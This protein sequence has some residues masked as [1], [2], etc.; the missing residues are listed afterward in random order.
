MHLIHQAK[1]TKNWWEDAVI[2]QIYPKSF[3]SSD[4]KIGDL[5]G[6]TSHLTHLAKLGVDALWISPFYTSPQKDGGYD[7]ANY[8]QVDPIFG[9]NEDAFKLIDK[10]HELGLR[11]IIDIVPNHTSD[12]HDWFKEA[13]TN[14]KD[15]PARDRYWFRDG[16]GENG[17]L[18]P[19]DWHS[20][21]GD[22]AWKRVCDRADAPGSAWEKDTQWYLHLFDESQPDLNWENPE[23][24]QEFC[25][26][27]RFWLAH[28]VD[29]FR[30]DVAHGL[31]KDPALPDWQFHYEMVK[32]GDELA[33]NVPSP[34][35]WN[36]PRVHNIY[37]K[38]R[39][40][41]KEYGEDRILVAEAWLEKITD[42]AQYVRPDEMHQNFNFAF[43]CS[44]FSATSYRQVIHESLAA[45]DAVGAPATWVLSNHDVV[46]ASSRFGLSYTG[47]SGNGI[48]PDDEQP[49]VQLGKY[50]ALAAHM[51]QSALP[52]S[53]YIYQGEELSLPEHTK[54]PNEYREDPAFF[55]TNG[56]EAGRDGARVPLPWKA[57]LP[58]F[59]FSP[60]GAS[61][62]PQP[63]QWAQLAIDIQESDPK[64][65]LSFFKKMYRLRKELKLGQADLFDALP[66]MKNVAMKNKTE[67]DHL[68]FVSRFT[69]RPDVHILI[70]FDTPLPLDKNAQILLSSQEVTQIVPANT[71]VWY[72]DKTTENICNSHSCYHQNNEAT[73]TTKKS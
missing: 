40:I 18:P 71:G 44:P 22:T 49:N 35:M 39:E 14:G 66:S 57:H 42:M 47:K 62:L 23:V 41:L 6:I 50:R 10:A 16:K 46:R 45:M 72:I 31:I 32:G 17:A 43:L 27:L 28:N 20:I 1:P 37:R 69:G 60:T 58:A 9:T 29:G 52:G 64:S 24:Q 25:D 5:S 30:V 70:T 34:P 15:T 13:L 73:F 61:W 7:V 63:A 4:G 51:L 19:N 65:A 3:A 55:R 48:F 12:Q 26:I 33:Q 11:V 68:H 59:G 36:L 21:F 67:I 38:W 54:I 2:Y 8:R 53:C 56:K